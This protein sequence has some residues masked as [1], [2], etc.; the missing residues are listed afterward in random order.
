MALF[1]AL[2]ASEYDVFMDAGALDERDDVDRA[3]IAARSHFLVILTPALIASLQTRDSSRG[4]IETL[5]QPDDPMRSEIEQAVA[6]RRNIVPLLANDFTFSAS[7]MPKTIHALRRYYGLSLAPETLDQTVASL[8][9]G[10]LD[11]TIFG[12]LVPTPLEHEEAVERR[13]ADAAR[14]PAPTADELAA[15]VVFNHALAR[16]RQDL[17]GKIVDLDAVLRLN[18]RHVDA[19]FDRAVARRRNGDESGA[20]A[21]YDAVLKLDPQYYKAYNNRAELY[22]AHRAYTKALADYERATALQPNFVMA[23]AGKALT[24]H[25]LG[26]VDEALALWKPLAAHDERFNDAVW[27]GREL[28]LPTTMI[29]EI[30]RLTQHLAMHLAMSLFQAPRSDAPDD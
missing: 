5:Q 7:L 24:L 2:R 22:F 3:Q 28:R 20:V 9:K 30:R 6:N 25:A 23:Q 15:E 27:V 14:L 4:F 19:R 8:S 17:A 10:R 11:T 1:Q 29:D 12:T 26:R 18:P 13:I 21:D 16:N